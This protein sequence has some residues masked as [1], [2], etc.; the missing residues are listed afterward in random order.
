MLVS[1]LKNNVLKSILY[2]IFFAGFLKLSG[3]LLTWIWNSYLTTALN[4]EDI[5]FLESV[6]IIA[7]LYLVYSGIKFGFISLTD[8]NYMHDKTSADNQFNAK[9][10]ETFL[11]NNIANNLNKMSKSEKEKLKET[12]AECC[13]FRHIPS[14]NKK[15]NPIFSNKSQR[16]K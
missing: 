16:M 15:P 12:I 5:T 10:Y 13:G 14:K 6:G 2:I 3:M 4:L 11:H 7:F 8:K 1:I 9:N